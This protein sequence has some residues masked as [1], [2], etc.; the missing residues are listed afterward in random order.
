MIGWQIHRG[1]FLN[2]VFNEFIISN[3]FYNKN[4]EVILKIFD[5]AWTGIV[6]RVAFTITKHI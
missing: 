3:M 4:C 2:F 1:L 6:N 5:R